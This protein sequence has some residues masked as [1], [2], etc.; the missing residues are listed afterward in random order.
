MS[1]QPFGSVMAS[2]PG[3]FRTFAVAVENDIMPYVAFNDGPDPIMP[4]SKP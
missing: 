4:P 3:R 2:N 1:G